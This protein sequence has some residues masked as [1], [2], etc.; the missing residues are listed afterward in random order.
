M[1]KNKQSIQ[2][3]AMYFGTYMGIFWV[4]KF[5]LFPLGFKIPILFFLFFVLTIAVPVLGYYYAK[6]FRDKICGGKV[7][8]TRSWLFTTFIYIF[9]GLL[10]SVAHYIYFQ[11]IDHGFVIDSYIEMLQTLSQIDSSGFESMAKDMDDL[12]AIVSNLTPIDIT[13]Q[14][15]SQNII[16]GSLLAVPT[17]LIVRRK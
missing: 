2:K 12:I 6:T 14:L 15:L 8:F 17:A 11:F 10:T 7:T 3:Y 4:L 13:I 5:I 9:A 16:Y 1:T